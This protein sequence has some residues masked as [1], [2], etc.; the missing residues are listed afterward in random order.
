MPVLI[1]V[2]VLGTRI[3][4]MEAAIGL[5]MLLSLGYGLQPVVN[6]FKRVMSE[7]MNQ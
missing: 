3:W 7:K 5:V 2:T 4:G 1:L 6:A